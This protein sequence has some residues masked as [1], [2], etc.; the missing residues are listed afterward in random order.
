M[1]PRAT[2]DGFSCSEPR[3]IIYYNMIYIIII[4]T[5]V[6]THSRMRFWFKFY[7]TAH[8]LLLFCVWFC[9]R[10]S[11]S[12]CM[13]CII[14]LSSSSQSFPIKTYN[15]LIVYLRHYYYYDV[16]R[17]A[18]HTILVDVISIIIITGEYDASRNGVAGVKSF[19]THSNIVVVVSK[20]IELRSTGIG[21]NSL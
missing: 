21:S 18:Q 15:L 12:S 6:P 19:V 16:R 14:C 1:L 7:F 20:N 17:L 10:I 9:I 4:Q 2:D 5:P 8:L 3:E 11:P 13:P